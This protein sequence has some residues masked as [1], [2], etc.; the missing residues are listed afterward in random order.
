M[1][2]SE[3]ERRQRVVMCVLVTHSR[4]AGRL[5]TLLPAFEMGP[6]RTVGP[7]LVGQGGQ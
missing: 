1:L 2:G 4:I 5:L 3:V 6:V 7:C